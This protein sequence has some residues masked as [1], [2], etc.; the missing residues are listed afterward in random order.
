MVFQKPWIP[1]DFRRNFTGLEV[2]LFQNTFLICLDID[3]WWARN[4]LRLNLWS[5]IPNIML[6][7]T[8]FICSLVTVNQNFSNL[9]QILLRRSIDKRIVLMFLEKFD[10]T[11]NANI[12]FLNLEFSIAGRR[13]REFRNLQLLIF[14]RP[15]LESW[16]TEFGIV[17]FCQQKCRIL[18]H[19]PTQILNFQLLARQIINFFNGWKAKSWIF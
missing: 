16:E 5:N 14:D 6:I 2:L 19:L 3:N 4:C 7:H 8:S 17:N 1:Q 18:Q 12:E 10:K 15:H 11:Y 9:V 13:N